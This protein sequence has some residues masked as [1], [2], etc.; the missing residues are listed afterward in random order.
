MTGSGHVMDT[1]NIVQHLSDS[2]SSVK[3]SETHPPDG[4]MHLREPAGPSHF[5]RLDGSKV[6]NLLGI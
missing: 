1:V 2:W 3:A 4:A 5:G 6:P